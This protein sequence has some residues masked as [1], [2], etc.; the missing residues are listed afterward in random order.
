LTQHTG[1]KQKYDIWDHGLREGGT[2]G[3]SYPS[4]IGTWAKEDES[5]DPTFFCNQVQNF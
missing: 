3:T 1:K 4:L 2:R 5:K